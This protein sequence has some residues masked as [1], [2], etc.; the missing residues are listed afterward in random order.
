MEDQ[1]ACPHETHQGEVA[2][3]GFGLAAEV[4]VGW[5]VR[6]SVDEGQAS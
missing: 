1:I 5:E 4:F 3:R 6:G 2:V